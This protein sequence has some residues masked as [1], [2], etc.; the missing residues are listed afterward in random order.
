MVADCAT[1]SSMEAQA[2]NIAVNC[3][4]RSHKRRLARQSLEGKLQAAYTYIRRLELQC[5]QAPMPTPPEPASAEAPLGLT[6]NERFK[7]A[8]GAVASI[9][10]NSAPLEA[11]LG[12]AAG[13]VDIFGVLRGLFQSELEALQTKLDAHVQRVETILGDSERVIKEVEVIKVVE[14]R[15]EVPV[16]VTKEVEV[17]KIVERIVEVPVEII[18][19][20]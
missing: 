18:R 12:E 20:V 15:V 7:E 13:G 4:S 1:A 6:F 2:A 14:K 8:L 17:I 11:N 5:A 10:C 3:I 16:E 9:E 19:E